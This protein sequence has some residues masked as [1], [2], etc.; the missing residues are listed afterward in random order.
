MGRTHMDLTNDA[1]EGFA[2]E[3]NR[4][5]CTSPAHWAWA[6]G[7]HFRRAGGSPPRDVRMGRGHSIRADGIRFRICGANDRP[8]FERIAEDCTTP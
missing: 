1:A 2:G 3:P 4:H 6:L 5:C 8:T 7:V